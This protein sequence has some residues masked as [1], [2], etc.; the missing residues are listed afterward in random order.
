MAVRVQRTREIGACDMRIRRVSHAFTI[1]L[2]TGLYSSIYIYIYIYIYLI[3]NYLI[4]VM[5]YVC[6]YFT[7]YIV[8]ITY[9]NY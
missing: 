6:E 2:V 1:E 8:V 3:H 4:M 9:A 7:S 5:H